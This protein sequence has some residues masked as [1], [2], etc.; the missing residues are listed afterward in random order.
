MATERFEANVGDNGVV[1]VATLE[2]ADGVPVPLTSISAV[3]FSMDR[4]GEDPVVDDAAAVADADQ[5]A[6]PGVVR[7]TFTSA[8]LQVPGTF[9]AWFKVF[10]PDGAKRT[11]PTR[12][13]EV[14]VLRNE[15]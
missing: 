1:M 6:N 5:T 7:F 10:W 9:R 11:F 14:V 15:T 3:T 12:H 2:D 13:F 8:H 4:R